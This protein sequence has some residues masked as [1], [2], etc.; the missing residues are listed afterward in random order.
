MKAMWTVMGSAATLCAAALMI[1]APA[2]QAGKIVD[3]FSP[4]DGVS[5]GLGGQFNTP[6]DIAFND[7]S[8]ADGNGV[9]GWYYVVDDSNHRIQAFNAAGAFQ[10]AIGRNVSISNVAGDAGAVAEKCVS[11]SDCQA[12]VTGSLGGMFDN[13]HG[14]DVNQSTGHFYVRNRDNLRVDEYEADGDFVRAWGWDVVAPAG[15]P[16]SR[17]IQNVRVT[18]TAGTFTLTFSGQTTAALAFDATAADVKAALDA[19]STIGGVG[20]SVSVTGGPGDATGSTPYRVTFD[21]GPLAGTDVAA[22]TAL[23]SGGATVAIGTPNPGATGFEVCGTAS[24][25]KAGT[26]GGGAGQFAASNANGP[27]GIA[28]NQANGNLFVADPGQLGAN[29]KRVVEFEGDGDFVRA[30]G[31]NV[32]PVGG[33]GDLGTV[34]EICTISSGCQGVAISSGG[35]A[36]GAFANSSPGHL[37]LGSNGILYAS[38]GSTSSAIGGSNRVLRFDTTQSSVGALLQSPIA[39]SLLGAGATNTLEVDPANHLYAGRGTT[40][41]DELDLS[42]NPATV[43]ASHV[44]DRHLENAGLTPTGMDLDV[45]SGDIYVSSTTGGHRVYLLD[46]D[47]ADGALD[48]TLMP[49]TDVTDEAARLSATIN[50]G[51]FPTTYHFEVSKNG[52]VWTAVAPDQSIGSGVADVEI[53]DDVTGLDANTLYRVRIVATRG[54]GNGAVTTA[55]L[56][57]ATDAIAPDAVTNPPNQRGTTTATLA[58]RVKPNGLPTTYRFEYGASIA[59]GKTIPV[60]AASAG[61]GGAFKDVSQSVAGLTPDTV[62]HYRLVAENAEG[63]IAGDDVAFRTRAPFPTGPDGRAF[64]LVSAADET[65]GG[66]VGAHLT[67]DVASSVSGF[68]SLDG[69]RYVLETLAGPTLTDGPFAYANDWAFVTRGPAGW[70]SRSPFTHPNHGYAGNKG[71]ILERT[72]EDFSTSV[73]VDNTG[74]LGIFEEQAEWPGTLAAP[75]LSDWEGRWE[76]FGPTDTSQA[77]GQGWVDDRAVSADGSHALLSTAGPTLWFG[78]LSGPGD[79]YIDRVAGGATYV[80]DLSA[81]LSDSFPGAGVRSPVG[82][83]TTGTEIPE[84]SISGKQ[85][86]QACGAP[87]PG[88][89]AALISPNGDSITPKRIGAVSNVISRDGSRVF[90]MSPDQDAP[91]TPSACTVDT[92]P[93]TSCP[94]QVYVRQ[95]DDDG[96]VATRWISRSLVADQD[97]S[98]MG[99]VYLEGASKDGDKVFFRTAAP[100][101]DDDPN[102]GCGA[103]CTAGSPDDESWD[104]YV[105]DLPNGLDGD[106]A[107]A[108]AD[109]AGGTLTRITGG[110][111]ETSDPNVVPTPGEADET[112]SLRFA[113][114]DGSRAYFTSADDIAGAATPDS[115]TSTAPG[116]SP[117]DTDATNLYLYDSNREPEERWTFV[118]RIPRTSPTALAIA[119][120]ASS[121]PGVGDALV[122]E[123][124]LEGVH[125]YILNCVR[126]TSDGTFMTFMTDGKLTA[127]DPDDES[128]DIYAFDA[129]ADE[130]SRISA[131]AGGSSEPYRCITIQEAGSVPEQDCFGDGGIGAPRISPRPRLGVATAPSQPG[132]RIA[133]FQSKSQLVDED[134]DDRYDVYQWRNGELSLLTPG[135]ETGAFYNGNSADG[136]DV[137]VMTK[138][139]LSWQDVDSA[140]DVY[141]ARVGGG[142]PEPPAEE[143]PC[144]VLN[145]GC[146]GETADPSS[147]PNATDRPGGGN[148][149]PVTRL[150]VTIVTVSA[151]Q[152]RRAVKSGVL[153]MRVRVS[154]PGS[155]RFSA[156]ARIRGKTRMVARGTKRAS[157]PGVKALRLPLSRAARQALKAGRSVRLRITVAAD[158]APNRT[159]VVLL[160]G[161]AR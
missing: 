57:F 14:V 95:T 124:N 80:D 45:A 52:T 41:I 123:S 37:A 147:L 116:G 2:A 138:D 5:G 21:G 141:D 35:G 115:G 136:Q 108:D 58:G 160:K 28:V 91:T 131:P 161:Q 36:N 44:V 154:A 113:S 25:C 114:D 9:D 40:G 107:T 88:R 112:T 101:T 24:G 118:A 140:M 69:E 10:F 49:P 6:R 67:E 60:P 23:G 105:Y 26:A 43:D 53:E 155:L 158:G 27:T 130:L 133:F 99:P 17:E 8:V 31:F 157:T 29:G 93:A 92:G 150:R 32:I 127:G 139:R 74:H 151:T 56:T 30:W 132:D 145:D 78:G 86:A 144:D 48:A 142:I 98:L 128:G 65:S 106:P 18:G 129:S 11:A 33:A 71:A 42:A 3:S 75:A 76:V 16:Q 104:L 159:A 119:T 84:R 59:Y 137:F 39:G 73:W 51:G 83:C 19:L 77:D 34:F 13:P 20:A 126:G 66:G 90:F 50:P 134:T 55:E 96:N 61:S 79:P 54:F 81:G 121:T 102:A 110:P 38:D 94:A 153:R 120:C 100:L 7:A 89:D 82:I 15:S 87:L 97:A 1:C 70:T 68:P 12:G 46:D 117:T 64:E 111:T 72:S 125:A 109:P 146:Q 152:R 63:T 122:R 47:G 156:K 148:S 143:P 135:T 62:Y 149:G 4:L 103:P 85:G 22:M